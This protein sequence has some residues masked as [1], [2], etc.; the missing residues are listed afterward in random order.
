VNKTKRFNS[1]LIVFVV[2]FFI[3]QRPKK[4]DFSAD[5]FKHSYIKDSQKSDEKNKHI[6]PI[7]EIID[8]GLSKDA[9]PSIDNPKFLAA[10][11]AALKDSEMGIAVELGG[12]SRF[13]PFQILVWHEVVNDS[14]AGRCIIVTYCPLCYSGVVFE[15]LVNGECVEF[16]TSGKLWNSNLIMYDR[17]TGGLWSQILGKAVVGK[18]AGARLRVITSNIVA[19]GGW[20]KLHPK[21][22]VLS[23]DSGSK[24]DYGRDP[25]GSYYTTPGLYFPVNKKDNRLKEKTLVLGVM[26]A[27]EAKAYPYD[28]VKKRQKIEDSL[29]GIH[30]IAEYNQTLDT[31]IVYKKKQNGDKEELESLTTFWF[32]W[33]AAHPDTKLY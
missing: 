3:W 10:G 13:Y 33:A 32:S 5:K 12:V 31:V 23:R 24:R 1:F 26:V 29:A 16:G 27:G 6:I 8:S 11:Q 20:K 14:I 18:M 22:E 19:F 2:L 28:T 25:Y 9:I 4:E 17:K 15:A 30:I 7:K 21:G